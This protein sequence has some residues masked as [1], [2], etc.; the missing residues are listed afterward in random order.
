[1]RRISSLPTAEFCPKVD[2]IGLDVESTQ[3]ARSTV[4]H[5]YCDSGA[6][7]ADLYTLPEEDQE[8]IRR[9][10]VPMPFLYKVG[11][12]T[13]T[14]QYRNAAR[15]WRVA[16]D[17][18]FNHVPVP[19]DVPQNEIATRYPQVMICGHLDMA[20]DLPDFDLIIVEDI[21][22]SIWAVKERGRSLQLHGYGMAACAA[23]GRGRY[24]TAIWDASDG[25]H[26][27]SDHAIEVDSF[28]GADIR[29]RIRRASEDRDGNFRTGTHC[30]SCWKRTS[31]P[32]HLVDVPEGEFSALL[33]GKAKMADVRRA[34][35]QLKQRDDLTKK[36]QQACK[37]WVEQHGPVIS[38]DGKKQYR[39][40]LRS[41][42]ESLDKDAVARALGV[43][44]LS[45]YTKTGKDFPVFDWRNVD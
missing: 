35:V 45:G 15:E 43:S 9:W 7:P 19:L 37:A 14:L 31:C 22:S 8:E 18:D 29:D 16:V 32:A 42:K 11:D 24:V 34:L 5:A 41:G 30:S 23:T 6:W 17:K 10:K 3:S 33:S 27:V 2:K 21:K 28:E 20:W 25:K 38:E 26:F 1:M 44:D 39:C 40:E 12:V 4:F 36:V 13:H